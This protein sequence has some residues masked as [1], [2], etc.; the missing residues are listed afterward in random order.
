MEKA[1]ESLT[2][3]NTNLSTLSTNLGVL[4]EEVKDIET[5]ISNIKIPIVNNDKV[6]SLS[7]SGVLST[8][9]SLNYDISKQEIQLLGKNDSVISSFD[10]TSFVKDGML[11]SASYDKET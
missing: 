11:E 2:T 7:D 10:A 1:E 8:N 6:L 4:S 5:T 3:T 9:L